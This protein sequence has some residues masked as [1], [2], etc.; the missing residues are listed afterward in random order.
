MVQATEVWYRPRKCGTGQGSVVQTTALWSTKHRQI[1]QLF[2]VARAILATVGLVGQGLLEKVAT[3]CRA[4]SLE[5]QLVG[6]TDHGRIGDPV[7]AQD[8]SVQVH[9]GAGAALH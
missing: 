8:A 2:L 6:A 7:P 1:S 9:V 5:Q 3:H 4:L